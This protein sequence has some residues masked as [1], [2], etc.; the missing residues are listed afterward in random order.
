MLGNQLKKKS[1][2]GIL[3]GSVVMLV[4]EFFESCILRSLA[5]G[6]VNFITNC[7]TIVCKLYRINICIWF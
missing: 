4:H 6:V 5:D 1:E 3:V 7:C 2:L